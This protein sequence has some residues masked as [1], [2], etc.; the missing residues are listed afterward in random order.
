MLAAAQ[1]L[2]GFPILF[3]CNM[4]SEIFAWNCRL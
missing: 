1:T 2:A 4:F 3:F